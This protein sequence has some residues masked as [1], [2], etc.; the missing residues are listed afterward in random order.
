MKDHYCY[1]CGTRTIDIEHIYAYDEET[2]KALVS[3]YH[4]CP[5]KKWWE[6]WH[7]EENTYDY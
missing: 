3:I 1:T 6:L 7:Y 4:E 5:N 2:G